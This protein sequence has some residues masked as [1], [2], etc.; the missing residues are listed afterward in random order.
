MSLIIAHSIVYVFLVG[1]LQQQ[2]QQQQQQCEN[3]RQQHHYFI[4]GGVDITL[5]GYYYYLNWWHILYWERGGILRFL[6]YMQSG[7]TRY[8]DHSHTTFTFAEVTAAPQHYPAAVAADRNPQYQGV[9]NSQAHVRTHQGS[10][11]GGIES[12]SR[13]PRRHQ[14]FHKAGSSSVQ[15]SPS[16]YSY[17]GGR[18]SGDGVEGKV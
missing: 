13:G 11:S 1:T 15:Q 12:G 4:M 6:T 2:Q 18:K 10:G 7:H 16:V 5:H 17:R 8:T 14:S 3:L 9:R